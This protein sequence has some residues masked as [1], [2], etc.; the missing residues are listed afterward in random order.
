[1]EIILPYFIA[2]ALCGLLLYFLTPIAKKVGLVDRPNDRKR[3]DVS[4]P[5]IGGIA[6]GISFPLSM[7]LFPIGL[8]SYRILFFCVG[9]LLVVGVL[10]DH[11]DIPAWAKFVTQ[12]VIATLLVFLDE[13]VVFFIGDIF[14]TGISQ[15]L[16]VFA[17]WLTVIA[18]VAIINAF[19][20]IDGH[21]G[22]AALVTIIS[23][24]SLLFLSTY[25]G[26]GQE[27]FFFIS[28]FITVVATFLIFNHSS[29]VGRDRQVYMG[30]AGSMF[31][32]LIV[33]YFLIELSQR[34]APVENFGIPAIKPSAVPWIIG[35]PFLDQVS[36]M[37]KRIMKGR[38]LWIADRGHI[39]HFFLDAGFGKHLTLALL[40]LI[41]G[42]LVIMGILGTVFDWPDWILFWGAI[43]VLLLYLGVAR[44][45]PR[46]IKTNRAGQ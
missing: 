41:H 25:N 45:T 42:G 15:G 10:D 46:K 32:G 13:K 38:K 14:D 29:F 3:H 8:E 43:L 17:P 1:V 37:A 34:G 23:L 27:H 6:M 12:M 22:L 11:Q 20:M 33:A 28:L 24:G 35:L 2:I 30:D 44:L 31:L 21:D 9:A 5:L 26:V 40:V 36:V 7:L 39:H 18:I 16:N 4:V 19:N